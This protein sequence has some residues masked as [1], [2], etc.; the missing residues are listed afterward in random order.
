[1][2]HKVEIHTE[3]FIRRSPEDVY[4]FAAQPNTWPQ[5]H[6]TATSVQGEVARPIQVGDEVLETDRFSFLSG[7]IVWRVRRA[8]PGRGWAIDGVLSGVPLA[9]GTTTSVAYVLV[10]AGGGTRFKRTMTYSIPGRAFG[11]LDRAYFKRHNTHQ[12]ARA[13]ASLKALLE[14]S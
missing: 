5:W 9:S 6:P 12:S 4:A 1:M 8:D 14:Q 2:V 3:T 13:V 11:W 10:G 7:S